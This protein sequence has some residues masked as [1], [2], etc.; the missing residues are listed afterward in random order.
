M[1]RAEI[2]ITLAHQVITDSTHD[3]SVV[4]VTQFGNENANRKRALFAQRTGEKPR[5]IIEFS[6]G[7][8]ES[9]PC[10]RADLAPGNVIEYDGHRRRAYSEGFRVHLHAAGA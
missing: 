8:P 9:F 5:L 6:R 7:G 1:V 10:F 4:A 2:K 3:D